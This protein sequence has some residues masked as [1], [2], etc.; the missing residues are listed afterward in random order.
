MAG[1]HPGRQKA[2]AE[3]DPHDLQRDET[4]AILEHWRKR[5]DHRG[6]VFRLF[7]L[8]QKRTM[9]PCHQPE[10]SQK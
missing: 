4:P 3:H 8:G 2:L 5:T 6:L 9:V 1:R 7:Q 10:R